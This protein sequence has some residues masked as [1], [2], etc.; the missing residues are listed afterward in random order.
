MG[1]AEC[2]DC[3]IAGLPEGGPDLG[4]EIHITVAPPPGATQG[5]FLAMARSTG[6]AAHVMELILP[7]DESMVEYITA[8]PAMCGDREAVRR[9][10]RHGDNLAAIGW[11][12]VRVKIESVP[13]HPAAPQLVNETPSPGHYWESH[14]PLWLDMDLIDELGGVVRQMGGYL[15]INRGRPPRRSGHDTQVRASVTVR[16]TRASR[17][18]QERSA[19]MMRDI[20]RRVCPDTESAIRTEFTWLDRAMDAGR[21]GGPPA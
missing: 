10:I 15:S 14:I 17:S 16:S 5:D 19:R 12:P 21:Y 18:D 8:V 1:C 7:S 20:V 4:H 6:I 9:L 3:V 13:W 11:D 2:P